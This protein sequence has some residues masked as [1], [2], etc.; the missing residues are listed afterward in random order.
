M[1]KFSE[2]SSQLH[3][4]IPGSCSDYA[5]GAILSQKGTDDL[6]HPVAFMSKTLSPAERNYD[7]Y[8]KEQDPGIL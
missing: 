3:R 5:R 8:D 6:L 2:F 1:V 7:I 4:S